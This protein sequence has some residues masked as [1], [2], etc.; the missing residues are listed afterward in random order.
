[1]SKFFFIGCTALIL[2]SLFLA[3]YSFAAG[4]QSAVS[5][6]QGSPYR[7]PIV[8]FNPSSLRRFDTILTAIAAQGRVAFVCEGQPVY[9]ELSDDDA[10]DILRRGALSGM[11]LE[12]IVS[13]IAETFDYDTVRTSA[14]LFVL[15]KRYSDADDLPDVTFDET[16]TSLQNILQA[17]QNYPAV[18]NEEEIAVALIRSTSGE[19][20]E[21]LAQGIPVASLSE[22]QRQMARQFAYSFKT[23]S[24]RSIERIL[25]RL[26]ACQSR[27]TIFTY[28]R[29][30]NT[31]LTVYQGPFGFNGDTD[32]FALNGW[33]ITGTGGST[34]Y[35]GPQEDFDFKANV[36]KTKVADPTAPR[37][38]SQIPPPAFNGLKLSCSAVAERANRRLASKGTN[39]TVTVDAALAAKT[40]SLAGDEFVSPEALM[41]AVAAVYGLEI[42][43]A[44]ETLQLTQPKPRVLTN[45]GEIAGEV[46]RLLP[47]P[48]LRRI[49]SPDAKNIEGEFSSNL[50]RGLYIASIRR[51]REIVEPEIKKRADK[52]Y[53]VPDAN[54]EAHEMVALSSL[55]TCIY[56]INSLTK[57][58]PSYITEFDN[59]TIALSLGKKPHTL[60]FVVKSVD[61]QGK[62]SG[63]AGEIGAPALI[64]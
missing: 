21:K 42:K 55:A 22:S 15:S 38:A 64:P 32:I 8:R 5:Q 62:G 29:V 13:L 17:T 54:A 3:P 40:V 2:G 31:P 36:F 61:A 60:E 63:V 53:P 59:A 51:L 20:R 1:M 50:G 37:P 58:M 16:I 14:D 19:L 30:G 12:G 56:D 9:M 46:R 48:F 34:G 35:E 18:R 52:K 47:A 39:L 49:K 26:Q 7:N 25:K 10:K 44:H 57:M 41:E 4:L 28:G 33:F 43:R 23:N 24:F 45:P 27:K 6:K 11:P